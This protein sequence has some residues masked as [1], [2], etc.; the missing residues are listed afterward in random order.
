MTGP[1]AGGGGRPRAGAPQP[2]R[3]RPTAGVR[4]PVPAEL[5][6]GHRARRSRCVRRRLQHPGHQGG[7]LRAGRRH[8]RRRQDGELVQLAVLHRRRPRRLGRPELCELSRRRPAS[9]SPTP[10]TSTTTTSTSPRSSRSSPAGQ[11]IAAD[12]FVVTDWMVDKLIRLGFLTEIDHANV[13][14]MKNLRPDLNKVTYD[15]GRKYSPHLAV[16]VWPASRSIRRPPAA[17]RSTRWTSCS[18][19]SLRGKVTLLTEMRDT[20]GLTMMDMGFDLE[21][22]TD[23]QFDQAIDKLQDAVDSGQV[24]RFTGNDYGAGPG[25]GQRRR[26]RRL[27]RRHGPACRRTP[28]I[29]SSACRTPAACC[30]A[31]TS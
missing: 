26:L 20:V 15:P 18:P 14:N 19:T 22:F 28:P 31:T 12:V 7:R 30:G 16:R 10:R 21:D 5:P 3:P 9:R 1:Y 2:V 13:P 24:R 8:L 6:A 4:R 27:D 23:E 29:C 11:A 25:A 17:A